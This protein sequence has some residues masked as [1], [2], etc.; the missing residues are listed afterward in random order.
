V[1]HADALEDQR[2]QELLSGFGAEQGDGGGVDIGIAAIGLHIDGVWRTL[3]QL[4]E[5]LLALA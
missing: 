4:P 1:D 2:A 3:H 5:A